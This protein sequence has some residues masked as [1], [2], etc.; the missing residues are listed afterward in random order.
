MVLPKNLPAKG[1]T[2]SQDK[3]AGEA[4]LERFYLNITKGY[5]IVV[6]SESEVSA[7]P[8]LAR[9]QVTGHEIGGFAQITI[10]NNRSIKLDLDG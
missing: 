1:P 3:A 8:I 7:G 5:G 10:Q 9:V 2:N 6:A 4:S